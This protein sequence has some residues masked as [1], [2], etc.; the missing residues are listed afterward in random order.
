[1]KRSISVR[2]LKSDVEDPAEALK[3]GNRL[4]EVPLADRPG[5]KRLFAGQVYR[6]RPR[7]LTFFDDVEQTAMRGLFG[8]GPG[9]VLFVRDS[10]ADMARRWIAICFGM[11]F[12]ALRSETL[13]SHAGL[14]IAMNRIGPNLLRS[15][16]TRKPEDA[17]LQ[18]RSQNSRAGMIY[19]FGVSP[20]SI[21]LQSITGRCADPVFGTMISGADALRITCDIDYASVDNKTAEIIDA[22]EDEEYRTRFPWFGNVSAI[23]DKQ[24]VDQLDSE[25]LTMLSERRIDSIHFAPP[26]IV[27]YQQID[28][29]KFTGMGRADPGFEEPQISDY[30]DH[31]AGDLTTEK[32]KRDKVR[33]SGVGDER[34]L[35]R[36]SVYN[37]ISAELV[38]DG[39]MYVL[40]AGKWYSVLESF[41]ERINNDVDSIPV[42]NLQLPR[43][44]E[45]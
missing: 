39:V 29:F 14:K 37:C 27:D 21:I 35:D 5:N 17:T 45:R 28:D 22:Y 31:V 18:T 9:A 10:R 6:S 23:R 36:W 2:I 8:A 42:A 33:T 1:M 40:S 34:Y 4:A 43:A 20:N 32:L 30:L 26:E 13:E 19:D 15:V 38:I 11:G 7:W 44:R 25:L 16:D 12:Q 24:R 3:A 41:V